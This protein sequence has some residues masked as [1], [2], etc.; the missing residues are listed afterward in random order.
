MKMVMDFPRDYY[1]LRSS[2]VWIMYVQYQPHSQGL[3][4]SQDGKKRDPGNKIGT[5][6][7]VH[8]YLI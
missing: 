7:Y 6:H 4:S 5:I 2:V 3:S 1:S 8:N